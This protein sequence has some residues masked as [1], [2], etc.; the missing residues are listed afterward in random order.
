MP[1]SSVFKA[2]HYILSII[3]IIVWKNQNDLSEPWAKRWVAHC[4]SSFPTAFLIRI[5]RSGVEIVRLS[6]RLFI[7]YAAQPCL[8]GLIPS[9]FSDIS[10]FSSDIPLK[11]VTVIAYRYSYNE[12]LTTKIAFAQYAH[13]YLLIFYIVGCIFINDYRIKY[14][15][16]GITFSYGDNENR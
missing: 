11:Y 3:S 9:F 13:N 5:R 14:V 8:W 16:D 2:N 7:G 15:F 12:I 10:L 4:F 6:R 1:L